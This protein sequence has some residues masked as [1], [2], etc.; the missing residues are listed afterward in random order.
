MLAEPTLANAGLN[1]AD[2]EPSWA[3]MC[4]NFEL[5]SHRSK[6]CRFPAWH[7]RTRLKLADIKPDLAI[8]ERPWPK[9]GIFSGDIRR[10]RADGNLPMAARRNEYEGKGGRLPLPAKGR[11]T[12]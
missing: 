6:F 5:G 8:S 4:P 2:M 1:T 9:H 11:T 10:M 12:Q 7:C 3:E